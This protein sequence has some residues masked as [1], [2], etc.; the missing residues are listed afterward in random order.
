MKLFAIILVAAAAA[1]GAAAA[2]ATAPADTSDAPAF[3]VIEGDTL[4]LAPILEVVGSRVPASLP[5]LVRHVG[6]L[7]EGDLDRLPGRSAPELLQL[8]PSVVTGQRQQYGVQSDL[9]IRGSTFEQVQVLLDGY[10]LSDPQSGHHLMNLPLGRRDIARLEVLPGHGSALYGSG[11]FGGTVNVVPHRPVGRTAG[12][13]GALGGGNGTWSGWGNLDLGDATTAMR[14]SVEAFHTDGYTIVRDDGTELEGANDADI[15]SGTVRLT[16]AGGGGEGDIF[17]GYAA[18][19][20]GATGFY[21]PVASWER[22][23]TLFTAARWN[24]R[25]GDGLTL[26]P[27][28][29]FRRHADHFMLYRDD[30]DRYTNDHVTRKIAGELRGIAAVGDGLDLAVGAEGV[31]ED[32][33]SQGIRDGVGDPALGNHLRR[34]LSVS[35]ELDRRG[36]RLGWQLGGRLDKQSALDVRLSGTAAASWVLEETW[37]LRG[38]VG[39]VYRVPTFTDLYYE[40]P[41]S[42]GDPGL[43]PEKGWTWD[44]GIEQDLAPWRWRV[45]WFARHEE[46][47]IDWVLTDNGTTWQAVN[48]AEGKVTGIE[49]TLGWRHHRG[50]AVDLGWTLLEKETSL[51]EGL[52]A[53]YALLAPRNQL[54]AAGTAAL[55]LALAATVTGRYLARSDGPDDFRHAFVLDARLDWRHAAGWYSTLTGTNLLDRRYMEVPGVPMPGVLFTLSAGRRF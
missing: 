29:F 34:R 6:I 17:A 53:R 45:T 19:E 43:T 30:P 10:D 47:L 2:T 33:D 7:D 37:L 13:L 11:A 39:S 18:R 51:P 12:E 36:D 20:F 32:I 50:H 21:A 28:L 4:W 44:V 49:S 54:T 14:A 8:V 55:P 3:V 15:A 31:Y 35:A 42:R 16:R 27:R 9:S 40:D 1:G 41:Y 24:T 23:R 26:E 46:D 22:T 52:E 25:V 38:S 48:I 5:G